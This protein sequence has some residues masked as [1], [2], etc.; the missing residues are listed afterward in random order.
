M[1]SMRRSHPRSHSQARAPSCCAG[2]STA[3][4]RPL[5]GGE[6]CI[7]PFWRALDSSAGKPARAASTMPSWMS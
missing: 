6:R 1:T 7:P 2:A 3:L 4:G 5:P